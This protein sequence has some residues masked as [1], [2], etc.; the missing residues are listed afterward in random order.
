MKRRYVLGVVLGIGVLVVGGMYWQWRQPPSG[1]PQFESS[2]IDESSGL[3][4]SRRYPNVFWTHNDS[5]DDPRIFAVEASG[6]LRGVFEVDGATH[7]DWEAI[8]ADLAGN[9]YIGDF[10]NNDNER[11][12]LTVYRV[13]EPTLSTDGGVTRGRIRSDRQ[14]RFYYPEQQRFPDPDAR[15][16][17]AESLFW[18]P[19]PATGEG[20]LYLLTKH[21]SDT[22]TVLYRFDSVTGGSLLPVT[23]VGAFDVGGLDHSFG[24][25][26][27]GADA[28]PD[29]RR[30][31]VVTYHA[32]FIFGRPPK[33]DDYFT[34]PRARIDLDAEVVKQVEAVA[35][36]DGRLLL[37]NEQGALFEIEAPEQ[38][39]MFPMG[40]PP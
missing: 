6:R 18:A 29:G 13:P 2:D 40:D 1:Y 12:D 32:L 11:R 20:T 19:H 31:A 37:T 9:L 17:D 3:T 21:R 23:R 25:M 14:I 36:R 16:F 22:R 38:Q 26:V 5:G 4:A 28:T 7:V 34:E 8:T 10:G 27:T 24:G 30:I 35:W 39:R 33:G 15:N